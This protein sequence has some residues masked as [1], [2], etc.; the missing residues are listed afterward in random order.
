MPSDKDSIEQ[1]TTLNHI[2]ETLN[3]AVDV[4]GV[5]DDTLAHLIKLMGLE[6][7]WIFLREPGKDDHPGDATYLLAAHHNLPP[8]LNVAN[9]DAWSAGCHCQELCNQACLTQA[10]NILEC[11]R[12]ASAGEGRHGL[13]LHASAPIRCAGK[14]L[15][16]LNVAGADWSS[17]SSEA[18]ALLTNV[19]NQIGVALER[20][21]LYDL[22][23]DQRLQEQ[24]GMVEFTNQLLSRLSLDDLLDYLVEKA[25]EILHA[26][27]CALLLPGDSPD[28]LDFRA[29]SGWRTDPVA[30]G[31][32][33]PAGDQSGPGLA[34]RM[35]APLLV[36]D[37][38][39]RDPTPWWPEWVAAEGFRGHAVMPLLA[40]NRAIG[41]LMIDMRQPRSLDEHEVRLLRLMANQ[42]A[43][44]IEQARLHQEEVERQTLD[45]ELEVAQQIQMSLLPSAVPEV[46]GWEFAAFYQAA[47]QIGG[48]FYD[49]FELAGEPRQLGLVIAD[50]SGKGVPGALFMALSRTLVRA[51]ALRGRRPSVA[52]QRANEQIL[53]ENRTGQ[54]VSVC[55][56]TLD[57]DRGRL[58]FANAGHDRPMWVHAASGQVQELEAPGIVLGVL[59]EIELAEG[60]V[61]LAPGDLLIFYT[62]GATESVDSNWRPFGEKRLQEIAGTYARASAQQALEAVVEAVKAHAGDVPLADDLTLLVVKRCPPGPANGQSSQP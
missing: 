27:A 62:D 45:K 37:V 24:V 50:V 12:L 44:A 43:L 47:Q 20:A 15:G 60:E 11:S 35:R 52:L 22:L 49:L 21:R 31:R 30:S 48:D 26:D 32:Q 2:A 53:K 17:F 28:S 16:I 33:A 42:T 4:Q 58:V 25:R 23:Q 3:G 13:A 1:L 55:Y 57:T 56:A 29:A 10:H 6:T 39:Q 51:A 41:A 7:G 46:S 14:I 8:A 5:L 36:E 38:G 59:D 61:D 19:G 18:L 9:A 54:F 40:D 34:M